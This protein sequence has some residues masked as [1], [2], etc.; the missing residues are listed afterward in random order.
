VLNVRIIKEKEWHKRDI[1]RDKQT[2]RP[3]YESKKQLASVDKPCEN[4]RK[5]QEW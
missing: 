1:Q 4:T 2:D 5:V 3:H